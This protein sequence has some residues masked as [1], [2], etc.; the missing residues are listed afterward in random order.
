MA[1]LGRD[2]SAT[3]LAAVAAFAACSLG[4]AVAG[5][6]QKAD[7][8]DAGER[9]ARVP[10]SAAPHGARCPAGMA[11]VPARALTHEFGE[12]EVQPATHSFCMDILETTHADYARCV[13]A[14]AC[15]PLLGEGRWAKRPRYPVLRATF[16]QAVEYCG[17]RGKRIPSAGEWVRAAGGDEERWNPWGNDWPKGSAG[18]CSGKGH[19]CNVGTSRLDISQFGIRD[20]ALNAQ[21]WVLGTVEGQEGAMGGCDWEW[22]FARTVGISKVSLRAGIRCAADAT[23]G[24]VMP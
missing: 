3:G 16:R 10:V 6:R 18:L 11:H 7:S 23:P 17:F 14:K 19:P 15:T 4:M 1:L 13:R 9:D 22:T 5:V 8:P 12:S 20:M 24:D 21:E 2:T